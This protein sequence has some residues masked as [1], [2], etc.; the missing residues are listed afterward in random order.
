MAGLPLILLEKKNPLPICT[1]NQT[2]RINQM[3]IQSE[4]DNPISKVLTN[5]TSLSD[6]ELNLAFI[7]PE[8]IRQFRVTEFN[9]DEKDKYRFTRSFINLDDAIEYLFDL[10]LRKTIPVPIGLGRYHHLLEMTFLS[11]SSIEGKVEIIQKIA[12][13]LIDNFDIDFNNP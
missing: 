4:I 2:E 9:L 12:E 7:Q 5:I 1:M 3:S 6:D 13:K 11:S 10:N 8:K